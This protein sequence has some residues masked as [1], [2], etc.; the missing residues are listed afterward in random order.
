MPR[1][2]REVLLDLVHA[3]R[4]IVEFIQGVGPDDFHKDELRKSAV[5][6]Q[7]LILGE[8][9]KRLSPAFRGA[10]P[11]IPW[12][13]MA[14]MRDRLIHA[15]HRVELD[16]VVKAAYEQVPK[17]LRDLEPLLPKETD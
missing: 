3:A 4:L 14:G 6:H 12:P 9:A 13:D 2:D 10:H 15:Y 1:D 7:I 16:R 8:A 11:R 5:I 17:L